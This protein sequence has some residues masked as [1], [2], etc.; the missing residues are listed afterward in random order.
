[1]N[2]NVQL[3]NISR[4]E[5]EVEA[6][7]SELQEKQA[8]LDATESVEYDKDMYKELFVV[9]E[10][11]ITVRQTENVSKEDLL[12]LAKLI[13]QIDKATLDDVTAKQL[14]ESISG[15]GLSFDFSRCV[16]LR[17]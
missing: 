16:Y 10:D 4:L 11:Y 9:L 3:A 5:K 14:Y 17:T 8:K 6:L 2:L 15:R 1:M 7:T 12:A 13:S